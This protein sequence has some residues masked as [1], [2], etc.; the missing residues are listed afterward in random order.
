MFLQQL[1]VVN[2]FGRTILASLPPGSEGG[3]FPLPADACQTGALCAWAALS[4]SLLQLSVPMPVC[5]YS[6]SE[7]LCPLDKRQQSG[8]GFL[9]VP[10][11]GLFFL[12]IGVC[13]QLWGGV[14]GKVYVMWHPGMSQ[15]GW[16]LT[17]CSCIPALTWPE[18]ALEREGSV[19][20]W[21]SLSQILRL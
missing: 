14:A 5:I 4:R 20:N 12:R 15:G 18:T 13:S 2:F 9:S 17:S 6:S 10:E 3:V 16:H 21:A 11:E 7:R 1:T 19:N 8:E